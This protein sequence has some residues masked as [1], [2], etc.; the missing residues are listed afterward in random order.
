M[1]GSVDALAV[2][3]PTDP[4][5]A[6][7]RAA[8]MR[9]VGPKA[10]RLIYDQMLREQVYTFRGFASD[11]GESILDA[12]GSWLGYMR[13]GDSY[14]DLAEIPELHEAVRFG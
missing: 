5:L 6:L 7:R 11:N 2:V 9:K 10:A 14:V 1:R 3:R 13:P 8:R 4:R 12:H